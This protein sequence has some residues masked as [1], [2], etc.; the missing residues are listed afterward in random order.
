MELF[1]PIRQLNEVKV[2]IKKF[3]YER[4]TTI[5]QNCLHILIS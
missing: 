5:V 4:I 2:F 3:F 1:K